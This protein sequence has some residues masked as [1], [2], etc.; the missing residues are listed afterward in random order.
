MKIVEITIQ[1]SIFSRKCNTEPWIVNWDKRIGIF[2]NRDISADEEFTF[3]Y[4]LEQF[5]DAKTKC[6]CG[7]ENCS[8]FIG[9]KAK[10][11]KT[12]EKTQKVPKNSKSQKGGKMKPASQMTP[13]KLTGK[14]R[15]RKSTNISTQSKRR[16]I[17]HVE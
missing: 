13:E 9:D 17:S 1:I 12:D 6:L 3:N 7:A 14:K 5:G 16:K 11:G 2:A 15:G 4:Q 8:G 10:S